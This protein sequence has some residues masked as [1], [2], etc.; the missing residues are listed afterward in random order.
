M[1]AARTLTDGGQKPV[2]VAKAVAAFLDQARQSLDLA[3]YDLDLGPDTEGLVV[4]ALEGA[5]RRGVA[6]RLAYNVDHRSP[7]PVP[8]PPSCRPEDVEALTVPTKAIPGIPDLMHHKFVVRDGGSVWTGSTNWTDDSW[9]REENVIVTVD[10]EE[11]ARAYTLAFDQLW[12]KPDVMESGKVEPRP[13]EVD[14]EQVRAW[15]CPGFGEAL[16][17]RVAKSFGKAKRRIRICSPVITSGPILGTLAQIAA[18]GKVDLAG[19]VDQ[20]QTEEVFGQWRTNGVSE[21]KIPLL[22]TVLSRAPFSAKRSTPY[23]PTSVHDYMHAKVTIADDVVFCGSFNLS[24][25][26]ERN[27]E[28]MLEIHDPALAEQLAAYVDSV[29]ARYPGAVVPATG[30]PAAS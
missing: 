17:H 15:F 11:L 22:E 26:G 1:I 4:G 13:V 27:A 23:T 29:R 21:W 16:A 20:T 2:E 24:R 12:E 7:I 10:S 8:P 9:S 6:V 5:A 19:C 14:G 30:R 28:N 3:L 25:S 18:E